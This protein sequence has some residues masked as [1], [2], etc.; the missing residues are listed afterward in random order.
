MKLIAAVDKKWAIGKGKDLLVDIPEDKKYFREET[1]GKVVIMGRKTFES[2]P[3]GALD[4]R[5]NIVLTHD[6]SYV[7]KDICVCHSLDEVFTMIE[8]YDTEDVYVIGGESIYEQFLPYCD[9]AHLT[10]VDYVYDADKYFPNLDRNDEWKLAEVSDEKTYF[11]LVYEF[12]KYVRVK[13]HKEVP[14]I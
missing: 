5:T 8:D 14:V 4:F 3:N 2:L 13:N 11:N 9:V 12:D 6:K 10:K 7:P 1:F